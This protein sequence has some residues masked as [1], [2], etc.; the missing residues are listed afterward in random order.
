M[1][2]SDRL[3]E[4]YRQMP[5]ERLLQIA[6]SEAA[7]LTPEALAVLDAELEARGIDPAV[8]LAV[9]AQTR[10]LSGRDVDLL[11]GA[12]Q[13]MPCPECGRTE[14]PLNGGVIATAKSFVLFTTFGQHTMVAC[15][16]CLAAEARRA[17]LVTALLGWWG[18][19]SG[20]IH[21]IKALSRNR[22]TMKQG[23]RDEPS[24]AL[25]GFV[26]SN[27]GMAT[28]MAARTP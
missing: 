3:A 2:D 28:A 16:D 9:E 10:T 13:K 8:G 11:V 21:T 24:K 5:D 14:R 19:P 23:D 4:R 18:F 6:L 26:A 27:P 7:G 12:V 15:P 20:P 25:L 22:T 1:T 17:S